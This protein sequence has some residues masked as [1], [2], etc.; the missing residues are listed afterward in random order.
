MLPECWWV[1]AEYENGE[2]WLSAPSETR[3]VAEM[4]LELDKQSMINWIRKPKRLAVSVEVSDRRVARRMVY[5]V[6][7]PALVTARWNWVERNRTLLEQGPPQA[8]CVLPSLGNVAAPDQRTELR[9]KVGGLALL[10]KAVS[11]PSVTHQPWDS[12]TWH[13]RTVI[14]EQ[15]GL[16]AAKRRFRGGTRPATYL[17]TYDLRDHFDF[18]RSFPTAVSIFV[19]T[20]CEE[21]DAYDLH[22]ANSHQR[23]GVAV[24][25][26]DGD[27]LELRQ[28]PDGVPVLPE[29]LTQPFIVPD[30]PCCEVKT[31]LHDK[32]ESLEPG[33]GPWI[34][35]AGRKV[36]GCPG[37]K[38]HRL[39][40]QRKQSRPDI[41]WHWIGCFEGLIEFGDGGTLYLLAGRN[42]FFGKW[43]WHVE[44]QC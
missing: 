2:V 29:E 37:F 33:T 38:Q 19:S 36:G 4:S 10:P 41:E 20:Y 32:L 18:D 21:D 8:C 9:N 1:E 16:P 6:S 7:N 23:I 25:I 15:L 17:A 35:L 26:C 31:T 24:P 34:N 11:W 30:F 22:Y 27:E 39:L 13:S 14:A 5:G 28:P 44:W 3:A 40:E 12:F 43:R 42:R